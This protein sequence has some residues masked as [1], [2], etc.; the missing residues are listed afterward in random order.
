MSRERESVEGEGEGE[1][2]GTYTHMSYNQTITD[3]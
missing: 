2:E 3:C 1:I